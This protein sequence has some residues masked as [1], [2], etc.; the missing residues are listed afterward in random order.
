MSVATKIAVKALGTIVRHIH[1]IELE[2]DNAR[3][4]VT[5]TIRVDGKEAHLIAQCDPMD[6]GR[7]SLRDFRVTIAHTE[8]VL[9]WHKEG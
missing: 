1:A 6:G 7:Y 5:V 2:I 8:V 9:T 3:R 4:E